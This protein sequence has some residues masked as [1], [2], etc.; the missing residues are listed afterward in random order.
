MLL[1]SEVLHWDTLVSE[2]LQNLHQLSP[3]GKHVS[4]NR[5]YV[6]KVICTELRFKPHALLRKQVFTALN[7][8]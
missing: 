3:D 6:N 7:S 8:I 5:H 1:Y 4:L 2:T